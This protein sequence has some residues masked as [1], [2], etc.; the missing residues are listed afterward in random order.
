MFDPFGRFRRVTSRRAGADQYP[1]Q[2]SIE[3]RCAT[4]NRGTEN[5]DPER[6]A[7]L[8]IVSLRP[9]PWHRR[10]AWTR[11]A[12]QL[13]RWYSKRSDFI[14]QIRG[15][16]PQKTLDRKTP[17]RKSPLAPKRP[18]AYLDPKAKRV[19]VGAVFPEP[20]PHADFDLEHPYSGQGPAYPESI[21][22]YE[23][24]RQRPTE[25]WLR[26]L[27]AHEA[28]HIV[29]S[30]VKP[31]ARTLGWLWNALEDARIERLM[32]G[33][34]DHLEAIFALLG[35]VMLSETDTERRKRLERKQAAEA[36][37]RD[38]LEPAPLDVLQACLRWRW[39]E[40]H[41]D[42]VGSSGYHPYMPLPRAAFG[43]LRPLVEQAWDAASSGEVTRIARAIL[44]TFGI[45]EDA[46]VPGSLE[47]FDLP[48]GASPGGTAT[49]AEEV[50]GGKDDATCAAG[51][52][53]DGP[54]ADSCVDAED[55]GAENKTPDAAS[56]G[57]EPDMPDI[58]P[59]GASER[60]AARLLDD[61]APGAQVLSRALRPEQPSRLCRPH[62]SRGRFEYGRHAQGQ[63]RAFSRRPER[64]E[65][66]ALVT[67]LLDVSGSMNERGAVGREPLLVSA[68]RCVA[69]LSAAAEMAGT[70][71]RVI[72][73][74]EE[75]GEPISSQDA[76]H[77]RLR[78]AVASARAQGAT[79]LAPALRAALE[80]VACG[81]VPTASEGRHL[82]VVLSDGKLKGRDASRCQRLYRLARHGP[83]MPLVLP[84][85]LGEAAS[86]R[87]VTSGSVS[88]AAGSIDD[89]STLRPA[90][91]YEAVFG[92]Y[93]AI[94]D[95]SDLP[96][97]ATRWLRHA[98]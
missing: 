39:L 16:G 38:G 77:E 81:G 54:G 86:D 67:T 65:P 97:M 62:R 82:I 57:K 70:H 51:V 19:V 92:R 40:G 78:L 15:G 32:A 34:H 72:L 58:D 75:A 60:E 56:P 24:L 29:F 31:R 36:R 33:R 1:A 88:P 87:L 94:R 61:Q 44:A 79:R 17:G 93:A 25:V 42:P 50:G 23:M 9:V 30:G 37:I 53:T 8:H 5:R 98:L 35:D 55:G 14:L 89:T 66:P 69:L 47:A 28:G 91:I 27:I 10:R 80:G 21:R 71:L 20:G 83:G 46:E 48:G 96:E 22:G 63:S 59:Q 6:P 11:A 43:R 95:G 41:A 76:G 52:E 90:E 2:G 73:F 12:R 45:P 13:L 64:R 49:R 85:L 4:E 18:L 26:G 74:R 84:L 3:G 68:K 7:S